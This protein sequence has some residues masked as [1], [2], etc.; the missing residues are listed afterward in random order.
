MADEISSLMYNLH[1]TEEETNDVLLLSNEEAEPNWDQETML[2]R[3]LLSTTLPDGDVFIHVFNST[4][5]T[6]ILAI[7]M[8]Q[9]HFFLF[10]FTN[11]VSV[12]MI[13]HH[14][15]WSF[16]GGYGGIYSFQP[17]LIAT[18]T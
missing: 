8:M 16:D 5:G 4:W 11:L 10:K 7:H 17:T 6:T 15:P 12:A 9:P 14:G 13:K 1:F 2:I 18:R 3:K